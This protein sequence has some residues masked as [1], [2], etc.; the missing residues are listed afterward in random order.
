LDAGADGSVVVDGAMGVELLS[1]RDPQAIMRTAPV[2][3]IAPNIIH[4]AGEF[5]QEVLLPLF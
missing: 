3:N 1:L 2:A 4:R 5:H